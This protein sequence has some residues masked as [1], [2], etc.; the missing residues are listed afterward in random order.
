MSSAIHNY[1]QPWLRARLED[2]VAKN[3]NAVDQRSPPSSPPTATPEH[4]ACTDMFTKFTKFIKFTRNRSKSGYGRS[5]LSRF[6]GGFSALQ[7]RVT[8]RTVGV[9]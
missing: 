1:P 3:P 6:L 7:W 9:V 8:A 4:V 2:R 5:A